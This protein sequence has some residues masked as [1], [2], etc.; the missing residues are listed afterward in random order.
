MSKQIWNEGRVVG[1][2]AY[3]LYVKQY[4]ENNPDTDI[5]PATEQEWLASSIGSGSSMILKV[6]P[7][8]NGTTEDSDNYVDI[9]LPPGCK[10][11]AASVIVASFFDGSA[12]FPPQKNGSNDWATIVTDYGPLISNNTT[13]SP[14]GDISTGD[15][16]NSVPTKSLELPSRIEAQVENYLKIKDGVVIQPGKWVDIDGSPSYGSGYPDTCDIQKDEQPSLT[17]SDV[18]VVRL[19]IKGIIPN[20]NTR[21]LVMLTGFA[22]R[23][24]L[25][26]V[27]KLEGSVNVGWNPDTEQYDSHYQNG[28]FIGP[29]VF[30]WAS[31]IIFTLPSPYLEY[32]TQKVTSEQIPNQRSGPEYATAAVTVTKDNTFKCLNLTDRDDEYYE[33]RGNTGVVTPGVISINGTNYRGT[34]HWDDLIYGLVTGQSV[35]LLYDGIGGDSSSFI[36]VERDASGKLIVTNTT[37]LVADNVLDILSAGE[38]ISIVKSGNKIKITNT[39]P[40]EPAGLTYKY[41]YASSGQYTPV[42]FNDWSICTGRSMVIN[43]KLSSNPTK[44]I[45]NITSARKEIMLGY[46]GDSLVKGSNKKYTGWMHFRLL[47]GP[48]KSMVETF[49][50]GS[51]KTLL[52]ENR[53]RIYFGCKWANPYTFI[54][55]NLT[56]S[57]FKLATIL[58][59]KFNKLLSQLTTATTWQTTCTDDIWNVRALYYSSSKWHTKDTGGSWSAHIQWGD[60]SLSY[61]PHGFPAIVAA[62]YADGH[63]E[64]L[65]NWANSSTNYGQNNRV[66]VTSINNRMSASVYVK[67]LDY[68][69]LETLRA[70]KTKNYYSTDMVAKNFNDN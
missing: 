35:D 45:T 33:I 12:L 41:L 15:I 69:A 39:K 1:Y 4:L 56:N 21:P 17:A 50:T 10:L 13:A 61:N 59:L 36:T 16:S 46:N 62:R 51:K 28:E 5:P 44:F 64:Q 32:V 48:S 63:N 7:S 11:S 67:D 24:V 26:G 2:S 53:A 66:M 40:Y 38:G 22:D 42:F 43:G 19:H 25:M 27:S 52:L 31:K 54:H 60:T 14:N 34:L 49:L 68:D 55:S 20:N 6:R 57:R 58:G 3:E 37:P 70:D 29:S 8:A 23:S 65:T 18:P 30:P 47:I 9:P